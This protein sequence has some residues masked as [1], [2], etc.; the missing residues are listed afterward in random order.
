[1]QRRTHSSL[2]NGESQN[3]LTQEQVRAGTG[4]VRTYDDWQ[5]LFKSSE[6]GG[7]LGVDDLFAE[8]EKE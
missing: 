7:V 4:V 2:R 1:M 8:T 6:V 3:Y 5:T